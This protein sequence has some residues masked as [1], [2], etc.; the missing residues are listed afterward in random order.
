MP[1]G[2]S[3]HPDSPHYD[4][5]A[6]KLFSQQKMKPTYFLDKQELLRH[7][8]STTELQWSPPGR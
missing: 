2:Q 5:Q 8:E 6:E 3:D 7:V 1:L 4:D